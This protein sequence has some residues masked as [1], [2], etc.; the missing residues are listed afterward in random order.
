MS[1][2]QNI[3][4]ELAKKKHIETEEISALQQMNF[5]QHE[6]LPIMNEVLIGFGSFLSTLFFCGF[7]DAISFIGA[8]QQYIFAFWS[9]VFILLAFGCNTLSQKAEGNSGMA[10]WR[11][12]SVCFMLAGK[13]L[14]LGTCYQFFHSSISSDLTILLLSSIFITIIIYP[15]YVNSI[16]RFMSVLFILILTWIKIYYVNG[17]YYVDQANFETYRI[18]ISLIANGYLFCHLAVL[19]YLSYKPKIYAAY[20]PIK[21]AL[22]FSMIFYF[23]I[24]RMDSFFF[25]FTPL[26]CLNIFYVH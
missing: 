24:P 17:G 18:K 11:D 10:F 13:A 23:I 6:K 21:Y 12:T 22:I 25:S 8:S 7:V 16:D 20:D 26:N 2:Y 9:L 4:N 1:D 5:N 3:I 19:A 15:F 14:F